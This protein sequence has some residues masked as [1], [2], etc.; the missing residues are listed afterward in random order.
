MS[1]PNLE[2]LHHICVYKVCAKTKSETVELG[3]VGAF[4]WLNASGR[5]N[6]VK[7]VKLLRNHF[8]YGIPVPGESEAFPEL[9][10]SKT[11]GIRLQHSAQYC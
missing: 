9:Q 11:R 1:T 5:S 8:T 3:E 4:I 6:T 10:R 2:Y 7:A